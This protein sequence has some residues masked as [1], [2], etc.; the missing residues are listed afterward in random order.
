MSQC[1]SQPPLR[2]QTCYTI[3]SSKFLKYVR[4][5]FLIKKGQ[6]GGKLFLTAHKEGGIGWHVKVEGNLGESTH[7]M[8]E[9][10]ILEEGRSA[11]E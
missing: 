3:Q 2:A 5:N 11:A 1:A 10:K 9:F 6:Q 7:E 8:T 4:D